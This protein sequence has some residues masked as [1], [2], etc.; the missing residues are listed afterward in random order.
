MDKLAERCEAYDTVAEAI[1][2]I[3]ESGAIVVRP[4][5]L[6]LTQIRYGAWKWSKLSYRTGVHSL[7]EAWMREDLLHPDPDAAAGYLRQQA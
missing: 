7:L 4:E 2:F 3:R 5:M 6:G 1:R